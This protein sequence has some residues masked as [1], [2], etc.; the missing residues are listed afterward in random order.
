MKFYEGTLTA[1]VTLREVRESCPAREFPAGAT[2]SVAMFEDEPE[3]NR[4][5]LNAQGP[6]GI[7]DTYEGYAPR[8]SVELGP[9][10]ATVN[11]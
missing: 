8:E 7:W 11:E 9:V 10:I 3:L 2:V 5:H 4:Y 1:P 6:G